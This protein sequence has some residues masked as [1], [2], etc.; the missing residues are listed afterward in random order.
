MKL[1]KLRMKKLQNERSNNT[2]QYDRNKIIK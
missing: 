1:F 2:N